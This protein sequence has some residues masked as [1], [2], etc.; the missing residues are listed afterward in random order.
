MSHVPDDLAGPEDPDDGAQGRGRG[1][2]A[3][4]LAA[5]AASLSERGYAATTLGCIARV[6]GINPPGL[7]HYFSS[8][9]ELIAEVI[10]T[11]QRVALDHVTDELRRA[12]PAADAMDRIATAV[13][14]HLRV[15]LE[16]SDFARAVTRNAGQVPDVVASAAHDGSEAYHHLWRELLDAAAESGQVGDDLDLGVARMLVVGALNWTTEWW[17]SAATDDMETLMR[18]AR[19][20]VCHGLAGGQETGVTRV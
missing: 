1:T 20:F 18:T 15:E 16:L 13:E 8:R 7:Y 4:I 3:R 9:E 11:G 10:G 2:R 5:T 6:A 17:G 19:S 14:A 12:G